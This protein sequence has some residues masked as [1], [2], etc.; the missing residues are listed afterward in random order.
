MNKLV[1]QILFWTPRVAGILFVLFISL[2]ALD[3]FDMQLGF[4]G[5][6]VGLF[7]HLIPSIL[8]TIATVIAWKREWFGAVLFIGWAIF[9]VASAHGFEWFVYLLIA[10]L[11]ALIGLLFL[12]G[13]IWRRQIRESAL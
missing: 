12:A 10:G 7:M 1:K 9:Y 4:W 13:W 8:L 2:F 3:I 11:P 6:V 5:T